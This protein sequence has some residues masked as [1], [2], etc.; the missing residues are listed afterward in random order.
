MRT[1]AMWLIALILTGGVVAALLG[2]CLERLFGRG[3]HTVGAAS[4]IMNGIGTSSYCQESA[5][6]RIV[7]FAR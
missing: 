5:E 1:A 6:K 2:Q 4:T 3:Q 7:V